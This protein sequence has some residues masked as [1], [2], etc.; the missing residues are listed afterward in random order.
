MDDP[1]KRK[2]SKKIFAPDE[3]ENDSLMSAL[4]NA[5]RDLVFISETDADLE[6]LVAGEARSR[7][8]ASYLRG[9]QI[10]NEQ[11][12]EVSFDKFFNRLTIEKD[13]HRELDKKRVMR[14]LKLRKM[15]EKNLDD[16]RVIRVGRIMIDIYIVGVTTY[17]RLAGVK[18]KAIET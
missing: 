15:L 2:K 4:E 12:E 10:D 11:I 8:L 13:W 7:S 9:L 16:L 14:F 6:P 17:G 5:C 18:T 1:E 3:V